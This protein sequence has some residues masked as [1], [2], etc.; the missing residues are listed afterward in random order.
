ALSRTP[1]G[2]DQSAQIVESVGGHD[3]GC[4]QLPESR[5]NFCFQFVA[6]TDDVSK[7]RRSALL[8]ELQNLLGSIAQAARFRLLRRG[9]VRRHPVGFLAHEKGDRRHAGRDHAPLACGSIL[10]RCWMRRK[11]APADGSGKTKFIEPLG[12]VVSD[13]A[14]QNMP[15]PG[16][17]WN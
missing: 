6:P 16:V 7:E 12:I 5:F 13:A 2:I 1:F 8:Q 3:S 11:P 17:S 15:L 4:N 10:E 9:I 14:S